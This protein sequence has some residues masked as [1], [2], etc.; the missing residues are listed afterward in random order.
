[1]TETL[2]GF[3]G[4]VNRQRGLRKPHRLASGI[5]FDGLG[6]FRPI[7]QRDGFRSLSHRADDF[8][9]ALV[10]DEQDVVSLMRKAPRLGVNLR[11]QRAGCI[12][13]LE[14]A[15]LGFTMHG[16]RYTVGAKDDRRSVRDFVELLNEDRTLLTQLLHD[17]LVVDD[18]LADV[19]GRPVKGERLLDGF[20]RA[21]DA[22]AVATWGC[23]QDSAGSEHGRNATWRVLVCRRANVSARWCNTHVTQPGQAPESAYPVR[24]ISARI[25]DTI[26][27]W[28]RIWVEGQLAEINRRERWSYLVLRDSDADM[29]I[30]LSGPTAVVDA[31]EV[32]RGAR[33]VALLEP[34]WRANNGK[35]EFRVHALQPVGIGELMLRLEQLKHLL[36][37]EGLFAP[38][39]KRPIPVLPNLVGL[40]CGRDSDA[41]HDV[42]TNAAKRW[43]HVQFEVAEVAVQGPSAVEQVSAALRKFEADPRIDVIVIARGGGAFEDLLP[44]S[45]EGL[46]RTVAGC[47]TP[48]VSAIGHE[49]DRPLLDEVADVRASTPTDAARR[50]VPDMAE[51]LGNIERIRRRAEQRIGRT[52]DREQHAISRLR[53]A[54][55]RAHPAQLIALKFEE[56]GAVRR[57]LRHSTALRIERRSAAL[58]TARAR[59]TALSPQAT[60]DRGFAVVRSHTGE[61]ITDPQQLTTDALDIR[62][63]RGSFRATPIQEATHG[64]AQ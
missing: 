28:P 62:V 16:R 6:S 56:V 12:D 31:S 14:A 43:P 19:H 1:M 44:F 55:D 34:T 35:F 13:G 21:V 23:K 29:S 30:Q 45:D 40:I 10:P 48:I 54:I 63:A 46:L 24:E 61:V 4:F 60:L 51:E 49:Q 2:Y 39:R 22:S 57:D 8:F 64:R 20:Y 47:F 7:N 9:M 17:V 15:L 18:F 42:L 41:K 3:H 33:V 52:L 27:N 37:A 25:A 5:K 36:A 59:L 50:I 26:K 58:T 53:D 11:H 38:E 32:Q